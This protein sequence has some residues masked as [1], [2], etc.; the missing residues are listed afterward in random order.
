MYL[1]YRKKDLGIVF[2]GQGAVISKLI[3]FDCVDL[4]GAFPEILV[5]TAPG[6]GKS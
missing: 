1:L 6:H 2:E 3:D 4:P 5:R